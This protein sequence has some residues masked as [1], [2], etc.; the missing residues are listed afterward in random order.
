MACKNKETWIIYKM[1][2][3]IFKR[4]TRRFLTFPWEKSP[5]HRSKVRQECR[6]RERCVVCVQGAHQN[7]QARDCAHN[8]E[9]EIPTRTL[10]QEQQ[11]HAHKKLALLSVRSNIITIAHTITWKTNILDCWP[12]KLKGERECELL[13]S[14][15]AP[16]TPARWLRPLPFATLKGHVEHLTRMEA[17]IPKDMDESEMRALHGVSPRALCMSTIKYDLHARRARPRILLLK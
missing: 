5:A 15:P 17:Q 12:L 2:R 8:C 6:R 9:V 1:K 4:S 3:L 10:K 11:R 7:K 13:A 16:M 14:T